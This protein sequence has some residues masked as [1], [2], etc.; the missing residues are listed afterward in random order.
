M[1]FYVGNYTRMGGPGVCEC[2]LED[3]APVVSFLTEGE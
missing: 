3:V 2:A 1:R